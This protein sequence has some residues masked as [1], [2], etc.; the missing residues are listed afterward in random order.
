MEKQPSTFVRAKSGLV[1]V[2]S[3]WDA[4]ILNI[5]VVSFF[6]GVIYSLQLTPSILPG[7]NMGYAYLLTILFTFGLYL[8]YAFMSSS[9]PRSG[10][11]YVYQSR[12]IHP[13]LAFVA[14]FAAWVVY[15]WFY[16]A[17]FAVEA[18]W[19]SIQSSLG[20]FGW[21]YNSTSLSGAAAWTVSPWGMFII[22]AL[23]IVVTGI[24]AMMKL[25]FVVR[26]QLALFVLSLIGLFGIYGSLAQTTPASFASNFNSMMAWANG[27]NNSNWY[28]AVINQ[29]AAAGYTP[30]AFSWYETLAAVPIA[31]IAM[32]YGFWSIYL[33]GEIKT[34]KVTKLAVYAIYGS[35]IVM[36][37][38]FFFVYNLLQNIG[39]LFYN[40]L[41][42]LYINGGGSVIGQI[43]ITPNY[44]S[45]AMIAVPN[46]ILV[47]LIAIGT[48]ANVFILMVLMPVVGS[49]VMFAQ[50]MD[51][52]LPQKLA[53]LGKRFVAPV[54]AILL[55]MVGSLIWFVLDILYPSIAFYFTAVVVG[56]L[57][58]YV[59]TGISAIIFPYK[60]KAA[61]EASPISKYKLGGI[62][63]TL[64]VGVLS[65]ALCFYLLY[66]YITI[67][68]LGLD[69]WPSMSI[70]VG[71]YVGLFVWYYGMKW[72]R[73]RQGI[74]LGLSFKEVPPE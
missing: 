71:V 13:A 49:R 16:N 64:I 63:A 72:Y 18:I 21:V 41:F 48:F 27:G 62:P 46:P 14:T 24:L 1:R 65:L 52:I 40:S 54:F 56:V 34:A 3:T 23:L 4:L 70:V 17:S 58:A 35:V 66:F 53:A 74:D 30:T 67:P 42:Y 15:Q 26:L 8:S 38:V 10:G 31:M 7:A 19:Q 20:V 57:L 22:G 29:A 2:M 69:N 59:L 6:T 28:Q 25:S 50:A 45:V 44:I 43:P 61:Y 32:G 51:W 36:G 37:V 12:L 55:Y 39:G 60:E 9:Y 33:A 11:D 68:A 73:R 5:I 47:A